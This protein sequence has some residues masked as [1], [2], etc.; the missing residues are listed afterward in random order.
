[1]DLD[2][3]LNVNLDGEEPQTSGDM[4]P[5]FAM[6]F[7]ND[8]FS[9]LRHS[10]DFIA[11]RR[12]LRNR[13]V[14]GEGTL[15]DQRI[16]KRRAQLK[17][18]ATGNLEGDDVESSEDDSEGDGEV[19]RTQAT[20]ADASSDEE[21]ADREADQVVDF[22]S[23]SD[24]SD[25]DSDGSDP[26]DEDAS[27]LDGE[28]ELADGSDFDD[29]VEASED[30]RG[31]VSDTNSLYDSDADDTELDLVRPVKVRARSNARKAP[32][33]LTGD[34]EESSDED[35]DTSSESELDEE[36]EAIKREYFA[37]DNE[38]SDDDEGYPQ[39]F[40]T[41]NLS[42]PILK[43][44]T[45]L[46]FTKPTPIQ[47][48]SI[49]MALL[50]KDICGGAVTGS[51][52]TAAFIVPILERLLFR[53]RKNPAV[54]VLVICPTRELAIQCQN[55][56]VKL[57]AFTD[58]TFCL[59]VGGLPMKKQEAELRLRPDVVIATPGRLIDHV[60]NSPSFTL[61][62]LEILVMDEADRM[63]EEGF[64][65]ELTE[66][67]NNCPRTRQTMLFSATMTDNVNDLIR[68]SLQRPVR[69]QVDS[70]KQ[71]AR[72]LVQEFIRVRAHRE[73]DRPAI[74]LA[75]CKRTY[76][77]KCIV[78]FRS[79]R[80]VREMRILLGLCGLNAVEL[81][82]NLSQEQRMRS[83]ELFR[84]GEADFLMATDVAARGLDIKGVETVINFNMPHNF[85][86]YLHRVGRTARAGTE[87]RSVTL[88]GEADRKM[89]RL[90]LKSST[91]PNQVRN[92]VIPPARIE[93]YRQRIEKLL[94]QVEELLEEDQTDRMVAKA[95]MMVAK[96]ANLIEHEAEIKARPRKTWF[97]TNGERAAEKAKG[98]EDYNAKF[99]PHGKSKRKD[100]GERKL[101]NSRKR[102]KA[103]DED[104]KALRSSMASIK[105]AKRTQWEDRGKA[106]GAR[107]SAGSGGAKSKRAKSTFSP[108]FTNDLTNVTK[109]GAGKR[110]TAAASA[111]SGGA[112]K[113]GGKGQQ[114]AGKFKGKSHKGGKG[115]K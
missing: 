7:D 70:A 37:S 68:L 17:R 89:L 64:K 3:D 14:G 46:N 36:A 75:L 48:R 94:P 104:K 47:A 110:P 1:M 79:K 72:N 99:D 11:A 26:D 52:K 12:T 63:L 80:A 85:A 41:M 103:T 56:A 82:G 81:H 88:A 91:G 5:E 2:Y 22:V 49:P 4:N 38:N 18:K 114:N 39:S 97:Q 42:R 53:S 69:I 30:E 76:Q 96:A 60:R 13:A 58:V 71:A 21:L 32:T 59:C 40:N 61:D 100:A 16:A 84:D 44:L 28:V 67:I 95:E 92:R 8:G 107:A 62:L 35:D 66:I 43:G 57:A 50:G 74:L 29:E 112:G 6:D 113:K 45:Q 19:G 109:M 51:G 24:S 10:A 101:P 102:R 87:G 34:D 31:G 25:D 83:L 55:V 115:R 105:S 77:R 20:A 23:G 9:N 108:G 65:A 98:K 33:T 90:A 111:K 73:A 15:L 27:E 86:Q 106:P 54:R 93:R 78:F